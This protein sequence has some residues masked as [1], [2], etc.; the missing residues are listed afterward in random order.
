[1]P[2]GVVATWGIRT[3]ADQFLDEQWSMAPNVR[4]AMAYAAKAFV[5]GEGYE[6]EPV[7]GFGTTLARFKGDLVAIAAD[8]YAKGALF[9]DSVSDAFA[10]NTGPSVNTP[11]VLAAGKLLAQV[12]LRTSPVPERV[13]IF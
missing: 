6:F 3:L 5:V 12:Q 2:G 7:D 1:R 9:G 13:E 10:V 8:L 11:A 4:T